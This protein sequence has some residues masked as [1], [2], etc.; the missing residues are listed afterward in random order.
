MGSIDY[1]ESTWNTMASGQIY[2]EN[3]NDP[4]WE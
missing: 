2:E 4:V 3:F 1:N